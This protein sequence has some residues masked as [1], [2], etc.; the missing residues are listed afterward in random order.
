MP[1]GGA[2]PGSGSKP[3]WIHGKTKTIRVP[4]ALADRVLE[5]AQML[6]EGKRVDDVT[7]SKYV[8]L[9]EVRLYRVND[10]PA[11]FLADLLNTGFTIRPL[12]LVDLVRKQ[13]DRE[14]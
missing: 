8:D 10:K 14:F 2:R 4:E 13:M 7:K 3:K 6:D 5:L 11:V 12:D 1:R 9:S